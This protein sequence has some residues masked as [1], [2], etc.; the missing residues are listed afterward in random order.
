[1]LNSADLATYTAQQVASLA[2]V[3][4]WAV[5][6][7]GFRRQTAAERKIARLT[8][9]LKAARKELA[10]SA[11]IIEAAFAEEGRAA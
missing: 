5:K 4:R 6:S 2:D 10:E 8:K 9:Q 1:M 7:E 3:D 11:S